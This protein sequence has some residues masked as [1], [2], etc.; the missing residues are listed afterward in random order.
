LPTDKGSLFR[1]ACTS[2]KQGAA[3]GRRGHHDPALVIGQDLV[4]KN[5]EIQ[6]IPKI[7]Q[8]RLI[9]VNEKRCVRQPTRHD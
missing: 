4:L 2:Q 9:G 5:L 1:G 7:L 3:L 6:D 8:G